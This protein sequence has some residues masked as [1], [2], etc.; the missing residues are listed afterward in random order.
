MML[1]DAID[2]YLGVRKRRWKAGTLANNQ[3]VLK[4]FLAD[5]GNLQIKNLHASH[6]ERFFFESI[7]GSVPRCERLAPGSFNKVLDC[8]R[9]FLRWCERRGYLRRNLIEEIDSRKVVKRERMRLSPGQL[10]ALLDAASNARDRAYIALAINTGMRARDICTLRVKDVNL[11]A[12]VI[13]CKISKSDLEVS[14]PISTD[15]D[16]ELRR[17]LVYYEAADKD[18]FRQTLQDGWFLVPSMRNWIIAHRNGITYEGE[19]FYPEREIGDPQRLVKRAL[20]KLGLDGIGEGVHTIRRSVA[21]AYFESLR[22]QGYD[23]ALQATKA[24]LNHSNA[25][26]TED[27]LGLRHERQIRDETLAGKEFLTAMVSGDNIV[28]IADARREAVGE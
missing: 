19:R 13:R 12:A 4:Q 22:A 10:M 16:Q 18:T 7:N 26:I 28:N 9:G 11:D 5:I 1:S 2:E 24:F 8:V 20:A 23:G 3:G 25:K 15:L 6:V 17:W 21:R 27:Y 14:K